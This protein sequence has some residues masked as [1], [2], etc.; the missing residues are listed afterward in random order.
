MALLSERLISKKDDIVVELQNITKTYHTSSEV[1]YKALDNV[2]LRI[3]RGSLLS[4]MGPSGHGKTT[5]LNMIGLLDR[6]TS[7]NVFIDGVDT[8][9]L[10]DS[11]LSNIRNEKIGF[12]FQQ[13]NLINRMN[14]LENMELP[15]ILREIPRKRRI[16]KVLDALEKVG[17]EEGWIYKRPMQLSGG[18]QQRVAIARAI[19][20][21]PE[22]IL[23]D[24]P[25][26]NLDTVS[27]KIIMETL[28]KL[29]KMGKTIVIVTHASEI[30]S[31]CRRIL[32][33]RDGRII[34]EKDPVKENCVIYLV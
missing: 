23:A 1:S 13:Y 22:I 8:G 2:S 27:S 30:S 9:K 3:R 5:L 34:G 11:E 6:P 21:D 14:I 16:E 12:V 4:I 7:G 33:I 26:G 10:G 17:G 28:I 25:T 32:Q 29:N 20:G 15:L 18:E 24:E 31:C 19:V